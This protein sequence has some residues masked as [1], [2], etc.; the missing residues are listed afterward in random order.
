M[1][2]TLFAAVLTEKAEEPQRTSLDDGIEVLDVRMRRTNNPPQ[3][4]QAKYES[5]ISERMKKAA[6][7]EA[8]GRQIAARIIT[9]SNAEID[10][11]KA[12]VK[13]ETDRMRG[14]AEAEAE[15]IRNEAQTLDPEYYAELKRRQIALSSFQK[16]TTVWSTRL[17]ELMFPF[18]RKPSESSPGGAEAQKTPPKMP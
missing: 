6:E 18:P 7:Y 13:A 17:W 12:R 10:L 14:L 11:L 4:R 15:R 16:D 5:I 8:E 1:S 3:T 2:H 9:D